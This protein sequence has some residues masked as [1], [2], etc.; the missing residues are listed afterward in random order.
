[1]KDITLEL[2]GMTCNSCEKLVTMVT[3]K[4]GGKVKLIN[5][6]SG[7]VELSIDEDKFAAL[8]QSLAEKGFSEKN[9][10]TQRGDTKRFLAYFSSILVNEPHVENESALFN[11][12]IASLAG[13]FILFGGLTYFGFLSFTSVYLPV[14]I[15]VLL[16]SVLILFSYSHILCYAKNLSCMNGMMAG[17][18]IG[19]ISGFLIGL[20]VGATNGMFVGSVVGIAIG[21]LLGVNVGKCCGI[22]GAL[23]GIMAGIMAGV[24]GAMTSIMLLNDNLVAFLYIFFG[25]CAIVLAGLSYMMYREGG[26]I[27]KQ[28]HT[29]TDFFIR[30]AILSIFLVA[31]MLIGPKGPLTI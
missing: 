7:K 8:K 31:F 3:E 15:L 1:M 16:S 21:V 24:M 12:A 2:N 18:T 6:K 13:L 29:L 27:D 30:S 22:M 11:N 4:Q 5:I 20:L 14:I 19:M 26:A 23:E 28:K 25:L 9:K 10:E 17:M